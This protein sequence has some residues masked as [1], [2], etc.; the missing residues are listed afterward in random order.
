M[1]RFGLL[2][3]V[4]LTA[5]LP[6]SAAHAQSAYPNRPV[7]VIVPTAAGGTV[8]VVTRIV[9]NFLAA[10]LGSPFLVDNRSGAGNTLGSKEAAH[11][12]P[13]GYTLLV[14]SSSGHVVGP[15]VYKNA[16]YDPIKSFAPIA[17]IADGASVLV[18]NP[19]RPFRSVQDL[20]A[21]AK[22]DPGKLNYASA[23]IGTIPHLVGELFKSS[24]GV[25][26]VHVPYR[27]G[28]PGTTDVIAGNVDMTFDAIGPLL[29]HIRAGRLRALAVTS[30]KRAVDLPD[31]PTMAESGYP[32]V[33]S[34]SWTG[35][36]APAGTDGAIVQTL[37][38]ALNAGLKSTQ[39]AAT[40]AR[41]GYAP[42]GGTPAMLTERILG[43]QRRWE[44]IVRA[45]NLSAE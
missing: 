3:F 23:G 27:G 17:L 7:R 40:L 10:A 2:A 13:D 6:A 19:S 26:I 39:V 30:A 20:V 38:A 24:A 1:R 35:L 34:L 31:V 9:A 12:D 21:Y 4:A 25:E 8:D 41:I 29:Q 43:E 44:P 14:T 22:A 16:G 18:V 32:A 42:T 28:A 11:A 36:F 37:N 45:L 15:L 33:L 5:G